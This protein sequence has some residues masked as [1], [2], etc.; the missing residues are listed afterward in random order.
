VKPGTARAA[1]AGTAPATAAAPRKI[2]IEELVGYLDSP[3]PG[4]QRRA[5]DKLVEIKVP[6]SIGPLID[7]LRGS[8]TR[9]G[10]RRTT[11]RVHTY[12]G[13]AKQYL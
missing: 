7:L 5:A 3:D 11:A 6:R 12:A 2:T 13:Q 1:A 8:G 10:A 4:L 9:P